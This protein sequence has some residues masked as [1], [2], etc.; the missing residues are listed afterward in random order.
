MK[1]KILVVDDEPEYVE[2]VK[3]V[4]EKE[5]FFVSEAYSGEE[6]LDKIKE[7]K[8]DLVI[9]DIL[10][11][12]MDGQQVCKVLKENKETKLIPV[13]ML[14]ALNNTINKIIGLK[15]MCA[16][17]YVTKPVEEK[18]LIDTVNRLLFWNVVLKG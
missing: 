5:G 6:C 3:L 9:L 7:E 10:M 14:T 15:I 13:V 11:P 17:A 2:L 1:K 4:L 18:E 16:D 8:P 12:G